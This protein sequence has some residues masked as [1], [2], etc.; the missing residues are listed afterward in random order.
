MPQVKS[1]TASMDMIS[2]IVSFWIKLE[3]PGEV[4]ICQT[5]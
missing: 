3:N 4:N 2:V 1:A 5:S